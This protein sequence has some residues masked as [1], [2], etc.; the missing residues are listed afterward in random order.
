MYDAED[1]EFKFSQLRRHLKEVPLHAPITWNKFQ[2]KQKN[3]TNVACFHGQHFLC[4][5]GI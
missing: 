5:S 3:L 2:F 4:S 1:V